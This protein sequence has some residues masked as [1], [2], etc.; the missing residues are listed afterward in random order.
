MTS[1]TQTPAAELR[2]A[3]A[4]LRERAEAATPGPWRPISALWRDDAFAA[5]LDVNSHA[6]KVARAILGKEQ[7]D[8]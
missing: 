4:L 3:A 5:V 7:P 8:A 2:E 1:T 6:L